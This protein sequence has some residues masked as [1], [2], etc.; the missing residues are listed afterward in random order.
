MAQNCN[1]VRLYDELEDCPGLK[2]WI[3][4]RILDK[5]DLCS[6]CVDIFDK[7]LTNYAFD[8]HLNRDMLLQK[9]VTSKNDKILVHLIDNGID[10]IS[11]FNRIREYSDQEP[12]LISFACRY[13]CIGSIADRKKYEKIIKILLRNGVDPNSDDCAHFLYFCRY[14]SLELIQLFI[15]LGANVSTQNNFPLYIAVKYKNLEL[16]KLF[17][18]NG[19]DINDLQTHIDANTKFELINYLT[20]LGADPIDLTKIWY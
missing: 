5:E 10:F 15:D 19:A 4:Y 18:K 9:C 1:C 8:M 13:H 6:K 11:P 20:D 17:V 7:I 14:G 3:L 2:I 12:D 16:V